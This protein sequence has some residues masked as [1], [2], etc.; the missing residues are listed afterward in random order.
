MLTREDIKLL[1]DS[2]ATRYDLNRYPTKEDL[3]AELQ[4][5]PTKKDLKKEMGKLRKAS[6]EDIEKLRNDIFKKIDT[7]FKETQSK[8]NK[9]IEVIENIP[10][11]AHELK[12]QS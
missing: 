12:K 2:F 10:V 6:K 8:T 4:V 9:R 1:V 5:Y 3:K 7:T 11:I